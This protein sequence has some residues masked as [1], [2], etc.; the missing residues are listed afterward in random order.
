MNIEDAEKYIVN[1]IREGNRTYYGAYGYDIYLSSLID[2][3]LRSIHG[4][5][6]EIEGKKQL[7]QELFPMFAAASW[8][9]CR[10][11]ILRPGVNRLNAQATDDG[12]AGNG[13]SV[14]PFGEVWIAE[15]DKDDY[16]PTEPTRFAEMLA[17][18]QSKFGTAFQQRSQ[19]AVRCYGA[20]AYLACCAMCGAATESIMLAIAIQK[21]GNEQNIID[22]Y[23]KARGRAKIENIII[24]QQVSQIQSDFKAFTTL[25]KYWRDNSAH[26]KAVS[27]SDNEAFTSLALLLRFALFA[28]DNWNELTTP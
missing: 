6:Y 10:R 4:N 2:Y 23:S 20:H 27:I 5:N 25:L 24:G 11:G 8:E 14:T 21:T 13:F 22:E 15:S 9:L 16:V 1:H 17:V 12:S 18:Y 19:E 3:Y 28:N 7:G 26:G